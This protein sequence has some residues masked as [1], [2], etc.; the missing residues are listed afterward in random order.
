MRRVARGV[1]IWLVLA[2]GACRSRSTGTAD[3]GFPPFANALSCAQLVSPDVR[4]SLPGFT[5]Q[6]ERPC[7]TCGPL[8]TFHSTEQKDVTVSIAYDCREHFAGEDVQALLQPTL[9]ANGTEI[10]AMGRA[11]A[12]REPVPGMLQVSAWD[13]D[14]PCGI[15]VTW[16]GPDKERALDLARM[17][18]F[19][20]T[21]ELFT[22]AH[23]PDASTPDTASPDAAI[24]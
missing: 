2:L 3:A 13:D 1:A 15:I 6:E 18:L 11:A 17:T 14:T 5:L 20:T 10:A 24:P 19:A 23:A 9:R 12:R 8:C 21:R 22:S 4:D 16:L 7:P